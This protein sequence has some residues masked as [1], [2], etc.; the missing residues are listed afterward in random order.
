MIQRHLQTILSKGSIYVGGTL[1]QRL[2]MIALL[3]FYG[4]FLTADDFGR[5]MLLAISGQLLGLMAVNPAVTAMQR[6]YYEPNYQ[7]RREEFLGSLMLFVLPQIIVITVGYLVVSETM[8]R[9]LL[10][11][12]QWLPL[13]RCYAVVLVLMPLAQLSVVLVQLQ[14]RAHR[15]AVARTF[16]AVAGA[17]VAILLLVWFDAGLW[18]LLWAEVVRRG[19]E[20]AV[21]LPSFVSAARWRFSFRLLREPLAYGYPQ[22]VS[23]YAQRLI[24]AGD[25]YV[26]VAFVSMQALGAY[27][28][29]YL[30]ATAASMMLIEPAKLVLSP[31]I[32]EMERDPHA[33]RR[34]VRLISTAYY[35]VGAWLSLVL[36]IFSYDI[37]SMVATDPS[38]QPG[39]IVMPLIAFAYLQH[40]LGQL[41]NWGVIMRKRSF[42]LTGNLLMAAFV[43]LALNLALVP[44]MGIVAAAIATVISYLVWNALKA[45]QSWRLYEVTFEWGRIALFTVLLVGLACMGIFVGGSLPRELGLALKV[46]CAIAYPL[47]LW[48][49]GLVTA[50]EREV[51]M[52]V[53]NRFRR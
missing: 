2:A 35:A 13:A 48:F 46:A 11:G 34:F 21:V 49:G 47:V 44:T 33:Q 30:I 28:F 17:L 23:G 16:A 26:L 42:M 1:T 25:R 50:Q 40:G 39:W 18:A 27:N 22:I 15:Y 31:M 41:L 6:Y 36:A 43:N 29:A 51:A 45:W 52:G 5:W 38:Y 12:T 7:R 10:G 24:E 3:P 20:C 37:V 9:W 4:A 32:L 8:C 14:Q 19:C 53:V